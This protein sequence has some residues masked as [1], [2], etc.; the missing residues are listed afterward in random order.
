VLQGKKIVQWNIGAFLV[1]LINIFLLSSLS[2]F[3]FWYL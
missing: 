1:M 3:H 2:N